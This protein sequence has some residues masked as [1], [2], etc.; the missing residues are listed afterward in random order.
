MQLSTKGRYAVMAMADLAKHGE[1]AAVRLAAIAERQEISLNYLEQIFLR[2]R[3]ADL[4]RSVR[5][6]GGGYL[7]ARDA[8]GITI[9]EIMEAVEEPVEMLR[10]AGEASGGCV[11]DQR[12]LTHELW[13]ALGNHILTFL[14]AVSLADVIDNAIA[15]DAM[16]QAEAIKTGE[17][18]AAPGAVAN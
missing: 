1:G 16:R 6:P 18:K 9:A 15:R 10:C 11:A 17:A 12:C 3:R 4:V 7:L 5:G 13:R 2:L 14:G 8:G